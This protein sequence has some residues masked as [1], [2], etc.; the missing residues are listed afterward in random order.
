MNA[1]TQP[2]LGQ[3]GSS[4]G[5]RNNKTKKRNRRMAAFHT[6]RPREMAESKDS[7][8]TCQLN[9]GTTSQTDR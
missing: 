9:P 7:V 5:P 3:T 2:N 6:I 1:L 4:M 8:G